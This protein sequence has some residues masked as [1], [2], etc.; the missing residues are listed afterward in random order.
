MVQL[1]R[2]VLKLRQHSCSSPVPSDG[3]SDL[4][5]QTNWTVGLLKFS[6]MVQT[7]PFHG[8]G[9]FSPRATALVAPLS[10]HSLPMSSY[11]RLRLLDIVL[12]L[13][14]PLRWSF[15]VQGSCLLIFFVLCFLIHAHRDSSFVRGFLRQTPKIKDNC[16]L[17]D[18]IREVLF[19]DIGLTLGPAM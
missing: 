6:Y 13:L 12:F 8:W 18:R 16:M 1:S 2:D 15:Y 19:P 14:R 9:N 10:T 5:L 3:N 7:T 17:R 11:Y 4:S